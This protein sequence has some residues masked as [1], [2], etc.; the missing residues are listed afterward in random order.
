[1]KGFY[2]KSLNADIYNIEKNVND[3]Q[4]KILM[5][6]LLIKELLDVSNTVYAMKTFLYFKIN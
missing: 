6:S 1:M 2:Q 3:E 4:K 5:T